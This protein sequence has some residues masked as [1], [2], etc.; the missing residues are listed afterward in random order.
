VECRAKWTLPFY[1]GRGMA[2]KPLALSVTG[3]KHPTDH[4]DW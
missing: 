4:S 2:F 3:K 1:L